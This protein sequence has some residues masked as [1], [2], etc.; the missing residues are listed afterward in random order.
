MNYLF[1]GD[2]GTEVEY[3]Q[4]ALQRAGYP[5][6]VDG[7][8]GRETCG[9]LHSFLKTEGACVADREVWQKLIPYLKG[10][11][12]YE[13]VAGDTLDKI[14]KRYKT[15]PQAIFTANPLIDPQNLQV[16]AVLEVPLGFS[17]VPEN[18]R[19]SY[20][21]LMYIVEGL[22]VRY[23]FLISGTIGRSVMRKN[24]PY[25]KIGNGGEEVCYSA[26]YHA[27]ESITTP[28]LLKFAE[29]Y[30]DAYSAALR[31]ESTKEFPAAELFEKFSLYLIPMVNPD[32]VDLVNGILKAG[33]FYRQAVRIAADFP[34]IPFPD[35]W[36]ANIDGVDLNLQFPA[37]WEEARRIKYAQGY[38]KPAPRDYVGMAPLTEPESQ[39]VYHFTRE[40]DFL[41][42]IAYHTQGEVIYWKYLDYEPERSAEIARYFGRVSG[43]AVEQTPPESAYAGYKDW[44][45][46]E[47]DRP[48]Y[49]IEAGLGENPLPMSQFGEIYRANQPIMLGGMTQLL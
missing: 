27:N 45:I 20:P 13:I 21:L 29:E 31:G 22:V 18:V 42:V 49:T 39:A 37:G 41:L 43:Y 24:I 30:C 40:H 44:F 6:K 2:R 1:P 48:G 32:G 35:G 25:L 15:T 12:H 7:I 23:P 8:F 38:T 5:T 3:L 47:Y 19:Y 16:E 14:A 36:K 10:Y 28:V 4:L 46:K 9:S 17:L 11:V 33:D 34:T 26:S